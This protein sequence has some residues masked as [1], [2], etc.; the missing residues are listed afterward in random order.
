MALENWLHRQNTVS[1]A[2]WTL[3]MMCIGLALVGKPLLGIEPLM[4]AVLATV[5]A[6]TASSSQGSRGENGTRC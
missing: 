1:I 6:A 4:V 2:L 5:F 3:T